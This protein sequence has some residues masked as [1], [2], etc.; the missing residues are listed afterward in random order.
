MNEK[1]LPTINNYG[2]Y[3]SNNYGAHSL[4]VEIPPSN[5]NKHGI[6]LY[7]SYETLIAFE[8]FIGGSSQ[9]VVIKNQWG[10]TTGKHLNFIDGGSKN[11]VEEKE[12]NKLYRQAL[13]NA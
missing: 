7:F 10:V 12:F 4:K 2:Y 13:K 6:T 3:S 1:Q 5:K 9:K 8:G 11:R